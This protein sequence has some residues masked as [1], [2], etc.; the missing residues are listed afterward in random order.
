M[1]HSQL[2]CTHQLITVLQF[3]HCHIH[4]IHEFKVKDVTYSNQ[5][6]TSTCIAATAYQASLNLVHQHFVLANCHLASSLHCCFCLMLQLNCSR[7]TQRAT[8][9]HPQNTQATDLQSARIVPSCSPSLLMHVGW[10]E[11]WCKQEREVSSI[12]PYSQHCI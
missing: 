5:Y 3:L 12:H 11:P 8:A 10:A 7:P 9:S 4:E 6:H 1:S 2:S